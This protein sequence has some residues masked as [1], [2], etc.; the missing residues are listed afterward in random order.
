[1]TTLTPATQDYLKVV[2]AAREWDDDGPSTTAL[3]ARLGLSVS[4]VSD[5]VKRLA[6]Q[7]LLEHAPY[8][9]I[10]LTDAGRAAALAMVRK[11]RLI[12]TF[13]VEYLGYGWDEVHDEA[14]VLEHAVSD[15]FVERLAERLGNPERDPHGDPIPARD[16]TVPALP[17]TR[18]S[19]LD[20]GGRGVV[21]RVSDAEPELLRYFAEVGLVL[22]APVRVVARRSVVG[23]LDVEVAGA[24]V[25]LGLA[26]ADAA[27]IV[28][29]PSVGSTP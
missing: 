8:G 5:G 6:A 15:E 9:S 21:A 14:E 24:V 19:A 29:E 27:W 20:D 13:L 4:S 10:A 22:D 2:W 25:S 18:L 11:H 7:G 23:T 17:A 12:E 3:A 28:E 26:A 16:G 1:M